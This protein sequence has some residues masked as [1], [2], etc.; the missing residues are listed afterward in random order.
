MGNRILTVLDITLHQICEKI[1]QFYFFFM[2]QKV[3]K[4]Y[5]DLTYQ[6]GV[7]IPSLTVTGPVSNLCFSSLSLSS[8][9]QDRL[10]TNLYYK[11]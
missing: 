3:K 4:S 9:E 2:L 6:I 8:R 11:K 1:N 10:S 7:G 5:E